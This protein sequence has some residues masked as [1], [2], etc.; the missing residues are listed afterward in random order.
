[1]R[2]AEVATVPLCLLGRQMRNRR[3]LNEFFA[4]VGA[5]VVPAI[6]TDTESSLYARVAARRWSSVISHAWLPMFGVPP[7]V[8]VVPLDAP[9]RPPPIGLVTRALP[10]VPPRSTCG[11]CWNACSRGSW[12]PCDSRGPSRHRH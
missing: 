9:A 12:R 5:S 8:R 7:G 4:E 11:V 10:D 3:I 1:M 6:E 2:W